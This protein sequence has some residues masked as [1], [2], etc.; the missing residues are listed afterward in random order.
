MI[1]ATIMNP[2]EHQLFNQYPLNSSA[3]LTA[4][5]VPTP[6]HIYDGYGAFVGG[7]ANLEAVQ[8]LLEPEQMSAVQ[9]ADGHAL[10]GLWICDF[11]DAS[12]GPH[13][14]LQVSIFVSRGRVGNVS[15][16]PLALLA[17]MSTRSDIQMM[18][19]GLW[20]NR[21]KTVAYNRELLSLNARLSRSII[22]ANSTRLRFSVSDQVNSR[23]VCAGQLSRPFEASTLAGLALIGQLGLAETLR[24]NH[25]PW[26]G[27]RIINP[28]SILAERNMTAQ[29]YAKTDVN[30]LRYFNGDEDSIA[31]YAS[32]Y[33]QLEF[34]PLFVQ[35]MKGFK[36]VYLQPE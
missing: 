18:C 9:T 23:L 25:K 5:Q 7:R 35:H 20:N 27:I 3:L 31:L 15:D 11:K 21:L 4:G 19:H 8:Q 36:F 33:D 14:E 2:R 28:V 1:E 16:H 10:M 22:E 24:L 6:Y 30:R 26:I 29:S 32:P 12:L 17:A 34:K 13:H